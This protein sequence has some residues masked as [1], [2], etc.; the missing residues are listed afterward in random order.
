[1][2]LRFPIDKRG[3]SG[4]DVSPLPSADTALSA[5]PLYFWAQ[6]QT[7][8]E[9]RAQALRDSFR[10]AAPTSEMRGVAERDACL[11]YAGFNHSPV[12]AA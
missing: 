4:D 11:E 3:R 10:R 2:I 8:A 7:Y 6:L 9:K 5:T 1:M 12:D